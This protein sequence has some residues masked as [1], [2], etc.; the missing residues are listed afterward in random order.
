MVNYGYHRTSSRDQHL[1]RGIIEI[2]NY[3]KEHEISVERI[4]T[5]QLTGKS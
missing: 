1:D 4:Y 3:C 2:E 5:D